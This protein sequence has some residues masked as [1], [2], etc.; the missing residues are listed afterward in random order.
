MKQKYESWSG[1]EKKDLESSKLDSEIAA[2]SKEM[3]VMRYSLA[4][5]TA[6]QEIQLNIDTA[7]MELKAAE[8]K[9]IQLQFNKQKGL[10]KKKMQQSLVEA[11]KEFERHSKNVKALSN[12]IQQ[13]KPIFEQESEDEK[14]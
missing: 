10:F 13:G 3:E 6:D 4:A 5:E 7:E 12:Q 11:Q 1:Q 8:I 14:Q 2:L 9:L